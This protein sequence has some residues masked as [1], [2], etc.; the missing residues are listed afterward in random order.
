MYGIPVELRAL[1]PKSVLSR[2]ITLLVV[3][4]P[5][6]ATVFAI[7]RLWNREV[8]PVDIAMMVGMYLLTGLGITIG[9]HRFA[10]HRSFKSR[11]VTEIVLLILG[12]MAIEGD[13]L[14]WVADH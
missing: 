1:G 7:T 14:Q 6:L 12:S 3:A 13:V 5:F 11:R 4:V 8:V 10:T 2:G 9:F